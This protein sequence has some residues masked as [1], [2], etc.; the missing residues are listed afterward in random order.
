MTKDEFLN[1][2]L[3]SKQKITDPDILGLV[4]LDDLRKMLED[5]D[6]CSLERGF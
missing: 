6:V 5:G 2:I 3:A 4:K 1:L